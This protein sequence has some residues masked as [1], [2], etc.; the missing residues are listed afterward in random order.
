MV[1]RAALPAGGMSHRLRTVLDW[2]FSIDALVGGGEYGYI[3][4]VLARYRV[5]PQNVINTHQDEM[6]LDV[7]TTLSLLEAEHPRLAR[8]VRRGRARSMYRR[9]IRRLQAGDA[10]GARDWLVA[11]A[12]EDL[13]AV[14]KAPA[15]YALA[16]MPEALRQRFSR[17]R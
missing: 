14:P 6:W 8:A 12:A 10:D 2:K 15:W 3:D 9:G 7:M 5:H 17:R 13:L 1:R 16:R 4:G 11:A